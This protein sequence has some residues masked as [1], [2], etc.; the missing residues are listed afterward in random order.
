MTVS[1]VTVRMAK[2]RPR[3]NQSERSGLPCHIIKAHIPWVFEKTRVSGYIPLREKRKYQV[4][5][6]CVKSKIVTFATQ[7]YNLI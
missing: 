6:L 7:M 4:T 5:K 2:S 1:T 3:K